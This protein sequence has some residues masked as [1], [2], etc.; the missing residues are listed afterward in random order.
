MP[1]EPVLHSGRRLLAHSS[2]LSAEQSHSLYYYSSSLES[3]A[4]ACFVSIAGV[5]C[6]FW[7][8]SSAWFCLALL[9]FEAYDTTVAATVQ[10]K[11]QCWLHSV[12]SQCKLTTAT[13]SLT[14]AAI[15]TAESQ[16][17][18]SIYIETTLILKCLPV[19]VTALNEPQDYSSHPCPVIMKLLLC[20]KNQLLRPMT[21]PSI[22]QSSCHWEWEVCYL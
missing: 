5:G 22:L 13:T 11:Q 17:G 10:C 16:K 15:L 7:P 1:V 21:K 4:G 19:S 12:P 9:Y 2:V 6:L 14:Q 18:C 8:K 3:K 20:I